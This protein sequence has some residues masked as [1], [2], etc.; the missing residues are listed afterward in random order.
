[1][2]YDLSNS[3]V[4]DLRVV[5]TD[6]IEQS[7]VPLAFTW[8]PALSKEPFIITANDQVRKNICTCISNSVFAVSAMLY[9]ALTLFELVA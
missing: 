5:G 7:A 9:V 4:D 2:E 1:M 8:Y 6:R 3:A